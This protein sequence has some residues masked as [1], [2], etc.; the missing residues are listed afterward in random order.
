MNALGTQDNQP[1][2]LRVL[3]ATTLG[4]RDRTDHDETKDRQHDQ[5]ARETSTSATAGVTDLVRGGR[6]GRRHRCD[7]GG[8][9]RS[10]RGRRGGRRHR[11]DRG[12]RGGVADVFS[13]DHRRADGRPGGGVVEAVVLSR[14]PLGAITVGAARRADADRGAVGAPLE[15]L[16]DVRTDCRTFDDGDGDRIGGSRGRD[17]HDRLTV[18]VGCSVLG[19]PTARTGRRGTADRNEDRHERDQW[20]GEDCQFLLH[21]SPFG[22]LSACACTAECGPIAYTLK[23]SVRIPSNS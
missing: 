5:H 17:E 15:L 10:R 12:S 16:T 4:N 20:C 8:R 9:R 23:H 6:R 13:G 11:R 1:P 21:T 19:A 14:A 18:R 7:R 2:G 22:I 3:G